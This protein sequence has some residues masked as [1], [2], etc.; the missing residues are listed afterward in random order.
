MS[1]RLET[2]RLRVEPQTEAHL[3]LV[4]A[5][6]AD[7]EVMRHIRAPDANHEQTR[8]LIVGAA[9][10]AAAHPGFGIGA[11]FLKDCGRF[12]GGCALLHSGLDTSR[13]VEVG[14]RLHREFW[15]LGYATELTRALLSYGF[16]ALALER[17]VAFTRPENVGSI[18]VLEKAGLRKEGRTEAHGSDALVFA[19][20]RR[21]VP[22]GL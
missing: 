13:D 16:G 1:L 9:T 3:E 18:R 19:L 11:V 15:G 12:V 4:F 6:Q 2:P 5:L 21:G 22:D 10:Y 14:Y 20:D 7:P 8:E 17:I